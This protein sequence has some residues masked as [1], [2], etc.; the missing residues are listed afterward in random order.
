MRYTLTQHIEQGDKLAR[1]IYASDGRILLNAG[2]PLTVGLISKLHHM[3]VQAVY[4]EEEALSDVTIEEVVTEKTR[5]TTVSKL[6]ESFQYVQSGG[7]LDV[8]AI[9]KSVYALMDEILLNSNILLNLTDI[10]TTDNALYMHSVNVCIMAV[11]TGTKMG[12]DRTKLQELAV[13][14]LLH[15]IGKIL[16]GSRSLDQHHSWIGF[17]FLRK[18]KEISTLSSHIALAHHEHINGSGL[19]RGMKE[20]DIHLLARI[21]AVANYYDNLV[22]GGGDYKEPLRPFEACEHLL[23]FTNQR[24]SFNVVWKFLRTIAFY[25]T[26]SQVKLTTGEAGI[27]ISQHKGLPQRPVVRVF[28]A[29]SN[30]GRDYDITDLDLTEHTTV[31]IQTGVE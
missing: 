29:Y 13:G 8:K 1:H 21:T 15:D 2:V 20:K 28:K 12:L 10:R 9:N 24:F 3:G 27:V 5:R 17:N 30:Q 19:P 31:F 7:D 25:P 11:L 6:A 4:L 26:G 18:N 14:A 16:P 22:N 23:G